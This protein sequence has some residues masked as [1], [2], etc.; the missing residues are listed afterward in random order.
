MK[1][2][3]KTRRLF[4]ILLILLLVLAA[5]AAVS[6]L[7]GKKGTSA[8]LPSNITTEQAHIGTIRLTTEG[9]GFIEPADDVL[10]SSDYT[11][12][13]DTV[14]AEN[15][16]IVA[17]GDVIAT[18]DQDSLD[19]Q[20]SLLEDQLSEINSS[21]SGLDDSG[22]SS[23]TSPVT[24]RIKR[25]FAR[26]DEYLSDIVADH[27]GLMEISA[28]GKLKV[29]IKSD[30]SLKPGDEV[31]VSFLSYEVDGTVQSSDNGECTVII[32]DGSNYQVDTEAS[33]TDENG[34]FLGTG[35]LASN[36]PY[37]VD[38]TYGIVDEISV[39]IGD[40]VD[41]GST[42]LTRRNYTY[43]GT[44]L[45]LL[46]DRQELMEQ[47]QEL[48]TLQRSP[49]ITAKTDGIVSDLALQ[50]QTM[51]S[52]DA[53]MYRLISTDRFWLKAEID[54]LDIAG[55]TAGQSASIVFDA[56]DTETYE[57]TVEKVS[58]LG[59]NTGG[60]TRYTVTIEVPGIEKLKTSM[61]ATATIV[62][63]EK[64]N[65]LI[66]PVDAVQTDDGQNYVTVVEG[67]TQ[68]AVPVTLGLVNNTEAEILEG[69]S[70]GDTVTVVGKTD[71]EKMMDM[72]EQSRAE[73][74][75]GDN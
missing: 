8:L 16:D 51:I 54:E 29:V 46:E 27:G 57:G 24:G 70:E 23:L 73:F 53:P 22:S 67:E 11:M 65:A 56:F 64:E 32:E 68:R 60:V 45:T 47:L 31:T 48:R 55:V 1:K 59:T 43:N 44:Y 30:R 14:E 66:V 18:V 75:G 39:D 36:H 41:A 50:E 69:L 52:E 63:D 19:D 5:L 10:V 26:P 33:V 35:Y 12:K 49:E 15:G 17:A 34:V 28:D 62:T 40:H 25:I 6:V 74:R 38:G 4:L 3:R 13:I 20:I 42:L 37:L 21:I 58:A 7:A 71:F 2:K 61:S 72:M 9:S